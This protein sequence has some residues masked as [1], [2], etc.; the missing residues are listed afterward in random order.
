MFWK[1]EICFLKGGSRTLCKEHGT[2]PETLG[3]LSPLPPW[4]RKPAPFASGLQSSYHTE[5]S[6]H[7]VRAP[8]SLGFYYPDSSVKH[9]RAPPASH[10]AESLSVRDCQPAPQQLEKLGFSP[11][12]GHR[13]T[14][15][16]LR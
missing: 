14:P 16:T 6:L 2:S 11:L 15:Q 10:S 3:L 4:G 7:S 8:S 5:A 9:S 13:F 1:L 12:C